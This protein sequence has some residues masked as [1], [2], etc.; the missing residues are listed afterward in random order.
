MA[1]LMPI[2]RPWPGCRGRTHGGPTDRLL[3]GLSFVRLCSPERLKGLGR[4]PRD[5][6]SQFPPIPKFVAIQAVGAILAALD[7][8]DMQDTLVQVNLRP[9]HI[10]GLVGAQP[11]PVDEAQKHLIAG[12]IPTALTGGGEQAVCLVW[13]EIPAIPWPKVGKQWHF[14]P[15]APLA[16]SSP[17]SRS[18]L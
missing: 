18:L 12:R 9:A 3:A 11:V 1:L 16:V 6:L 10:E 14:L 8:C 5:L 15:K 13:P 4:G 7:P 2:S 17:S